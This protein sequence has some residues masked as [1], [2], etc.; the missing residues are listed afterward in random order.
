MSEH[1]KIKFE[2]GLVE[3]GDETALNRLFERAEAGEEL[4]VGFLGGSITQG[5]VASDDT[6]CYAYR[7]FD[8]FVKTFPKSHFTYVN[9]GIGATDSEYAAA[10]VAEDLLSA[11]PD[12]VLMEFAVNEGPTDHY[13]ETYEGTLRQILTSKPDIA[14]VLMC[15]VFYDEGRNAER[16]HR[17]VA[18]H[19]DIPVLSM[20]T[21]IYEAILSGD[22]DK[23][24][25]TSDDLHPNDYGHGLVA[26][27]ITT[28]LES[29]SDKCTAKAG[30]TEKTDGNAG[31]REIPAPLTAN[32]YEKSVKYD[33]RNSDAVIRGIQGFTPDDTPREAV[34][35]CFRYGYSATQTGSF[36]EYE[37]NGACIAVQF[38]RTVNL[39]APVA[40]V[41]VDGDE[42]T[43][44]M[45][46]ANFDQTWGDFLALTDIYIS[47]K[48]SVHTVRIEITESHPDDKGD[49]YL[50][51][52]LVSG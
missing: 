49:F 52:I 29:V 25:I 40:Y 28:Y 20:R 19:Y 50:A 13:T 6:L 21:T 4:T 15:N 22:L 32:R 2:D 36:I 44:T 51:G 42:S 39:P 35:D 46:D 37:V 48:P 38:K 11:K 14:V 23:S 10:R 34:R 3:S 1:E 16:I 43:A 17:L 7:V 12:F 47:D 18:R 24:M 27:V 33:K 30:E 41:T 5:S 9:A 45:L 31:R 26:R 8:W